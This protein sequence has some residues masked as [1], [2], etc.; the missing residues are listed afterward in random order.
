MCEGPYQGIFWF[1]CSFVGEEERCNFSETE[2]LAVAVPC[3][4][5]R[6]EALPEGCVFNSRKGDA[7]THRKTWAMLTEK[8]RD[9]RRYDWNYFPRGRVEI[10]RGKAVIFMN[11]CILSCENFQEKLVERF[12]LEGV[13]MR[14]AADCS[15][16]YHCHGD[17][18]NTGR[19]IADSMGRRKQSHDRKQ[20]L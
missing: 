8:R 16:H 11:P 7:F 2:L 18:R 3:G 17:G 15:W 19:K 1:T 12:H 20:D 14:I 4:E 6:E 13:K 9:L 5:G 10:R